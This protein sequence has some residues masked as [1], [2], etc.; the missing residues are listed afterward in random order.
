[1]TMKSINQAHQR[2]SK[3]LLILLTCFIIPIFIT[4]CK[5]QSLKD[6]TLKDITFFSIN[7]VNASISDSDINLTLPA[8]TDVSNLVAIFTTTG[9][10]VSVNGI[11]QQNGVT[12]NDFTNPVTYTV[13]AEDNTT[14]D[15]NV[16]VTI[17]VV[18]ENT[19]PIADGQTVTTL[20]DRMVSII[21]YG[22][23]AD[24]DTLSF[25]VQSDPQ[26]GTLS[27]TPPHLS[28]IPNSGFIGT[29]ALTFIVLDNQ[30]QSTPAT[31]SINVT[32]DTTDVVKVFLMAGQSNMEGNNTKIPSLEQLICRANSDFTLQGATCGSFDIGNEELTKLF[33]NLED[34]LNDYYA[35]LNDYSE[36]PVTNKLGGFLCEAGK[37]SLPNEIC[38]MQNFDL[39]GRLFADICEYYFNDSTLV[40]AWG[41]DAFKQMTA[42]MEV[43]DIFYEG[44][45]NSDLLAEREDVTVLQ[46]RGSLVN[47][48]TLTL[49][50]RK[51]LLSPGFGSRTDNYGPELVFGHYM[52]NLI[53]NDV[54]LLKVVQGGTDL[55]VDWKT[56]CSTENSGNNFTS[57]ELAQDSLYDALISKAIELQDPDQLAAYFPQYAGKRIQIAGFVWFQGWNDGGQAV[58]EANY[59]TNLTCLINDLRSDLGL[60]NLPVVIA[61][62]H[63]GG[64]NG[65]VPVA[66]AQVAANMDH[67]ELAITNDLS[68]YYHFDTAAHLAIGKRMAKK[69]SQLVASDNAL[70]TAGDQYINM[71]A[72]EL[73]ARPI[74]LAGHDVE[75]DALTYTIISMPSH[76]QLLGT[77]PR[78][79]YQPEST[80]N[81]QDTF[82][83]AA[84]DAGGMSNIATVTIDVT[85]ESCT[86]NQL[87]GPVDGLF[88]HVPSHAVT[89]DISPYKHEVTLVG[90]I[91]HESASSDP[92]LENH[93]SF[94]SRNDL[95][96]KTIGINL[97][98]NN[99]ATPMTISFRLIPAT[100]NQSQTIVKAGAF[101]ISDENATINSRFSDTTGGHTLVTNDVS[102]LK[103]HSCNHFALVV[104]NNALI[105]YLN[106]KPTRE[107]VSSILLTLNGMLQVGPYDGEVWDI[108]VYE[109]ALS[110]AEILEL[111]DTC[112]DE[113]LAADRIEG[114]PNYLCRVY[115]CEFWPD[116]T[117]DTT[118]ENYQHYVLAQD[119]VYERN[120]FEA[121]MYPDDSFSDYILVSDPGKNLILSDGIRK[122]FVNPFDFNRPLTQRN[123]QHWLH[124][125]F[126]SF[127]GRLNKYPGYSGSKFLL[128]STASWGAV[129]N[130]P[131][132]Y[133]TLLGYYTLHPHLPFWTIQNSPVDD[134][135]GWEFKGGHQY[136]ANIFWAYLTEYVVGKRLIGDIFKDSRSGVSDTQAA[137]DLLAKQGHDMK[138]VF[139]DFAARITTWDIQDGEA[140]AKSERGSLNRMK[141]AFPD[142]LV[143]DAK[144]TALYDTSGTGNQWIDV[145]KEYSPGSWGFNAYK[146][147]VDQA[148]NYIVGLKTNSA[149]P[150][151]ADFQ[152]RVVIHDTQTG[153]RQYH[154]LPDAE[155]GEPSTMTIEAKAGDVLYLI[156]AATPDIFSGW[157]SYDYQYMIY[158]E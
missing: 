65:P 3:I 50:Q 103:V 73:L 99:L 18:Q 68:G 23:D 78:L 83:Y 94:I 60:P 141:G 149:N 116:N 87:E 30:D 25:M 80:F 126:H 122:T 69:M 8:S 98:S 70:P 55:R 19:A 104:D 82:T 14:K 77:P 53:D 81:G 28:Y 21:L 117:D 89:A 152:A 134:K 147:E 38:N 110:Q 4:G 95:S 158:T 130:I 37:L 12:A 125:N 34:P 86:S 88:V 1:M 5:E 76:G 139:A 151:Y 47:E 43:T 71:R 72:A 7:N 11:E 62:S 67:T 45:L 22:S 54:L 101:E 13:M 140:Y 138:S 42:A 137:F 96:N 10:S 15:Y 59:E 102:Q 114:Y 52:G 120:M 123:G 135:I 153:E 156:V 74:T 109:R 85:I 118:T 48:S 33:L 97:G 16:G 154:T 108:R 129:H 40:Y 9:V 32:G 113:P 124:E 133:D 24:G 90:D 106:G 155:E 49:S 27:G 56:P 66:Q 115:V 41:H 143:H 144:I 127:Q 26:N 17:E 63:R 75:G 136:G 51:G 39:T 100:S 112:A 157:D 105:S 57:E 92:D 107:S 84:L 131:G 36:S 145:P 93:P 119:R 20:M 146:V 35:A 29:D 150:E 128:E 31:V 91:M 44:H 142:A 6:I 148:S 2:I 111:A 121:G 64:A 79:E 61:Q 132:V 46:F 58:N